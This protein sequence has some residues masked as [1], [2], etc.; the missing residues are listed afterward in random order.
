MKSLRT[1]IAVVVVGLASG[2]LRA[3]A[4]VAL[5]F[6]APLAA[7]AQEDTEELRQQIERERQL[8]VEQMRQ[9]QEQVERLDEL[10]R[11]LD[12][13]IEPTGEASAPLAMKSE[14]DAPDSTG[15]S[16]ST[17]E[18]PGEVLPG[19]VRETHELLTRDE[20]ISDDF[21]GSWPMFG[22]DK[23]LKIGGYVKTDF[24][25]D[26]DGTLEPKQFLLRTIP[27]EGTP[28]YGGDSYFEAFAN[29]SR[30]N[31]D[32][33]STDP[34]Q[35]PIRAF[36]EGDFF[37]SDNEFRLRHAYISAG[38]FIIGQTWTTL[39]FLE[40]LPYTVDFA[41]GDGV[42][43]GRAAQIRYQRKVSD[44]LKFSVALEDVQFIG[45]QNANNLPG[46]PTTQLPYLA[47][48]ADY[49]YDSGVLLLGA[50]LGQLHWDGGT[51][52]P[53]D[54]EVQFALLAGGRHSLG[55]R[56]YASWNVS[57]GNGSG[58]NIL[59]FAGT[60]ANAVLD[61]DGVLDAFP[62]FSALVGFGYDWTASLSSNLGWA[63]GWL[64][65][66]DSR[67]PLALERGGT[68]HLNLIWQPSDDFSTGVEFM[69][70]RTR[71]QN[72]SEG[73]AKRLQAMAKYEF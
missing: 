30:F 21:P 3:V 60:E 70:G 65:T 52:G 4:L 15:D 72:G 23:R 69:W 17:G 57:Y 6:L 61:A 50:G 49:R 27:V 42:F 67:A 43:G 5:V 24:V 64:D 66:P 32:V 73:R 22:K 19:D 58:E 1:L 46:R 33:R 53:S 45:I 59:A 25:A 48:R 31:L 34:D 55:G 2:V 40:T 68:G 14:A 8:L 29:E 44:R 20:L 7:G 35:V 28:E 38:D 37:S 51:E 47:L 16:G 54:S 71:A 12:A 39:S 63:Y 18:T 56:A 11:K 62:S 41:A 9:L 26:L 13:S 10:E 36:I